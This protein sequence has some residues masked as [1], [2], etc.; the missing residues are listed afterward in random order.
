MELGMAEVT[1][2]VADRSPIEVRTNMESYECR[3]LILSGGAS[4]K[5]LG[6]PGEQELIGKGV[7]YCAH[8]DGGQFADKS[9]V[10]VGGGNSGLT[11]A[12]YLS[13]IASRITILEILPELR[14]LPLLVDR[15]REQ[16]NIDVR[17]GVRISAIEGAQRV[18]G[19]VCCEN[20]GAQTEQVATDGVLVRIGYDPETE[21]L[22]ESVSLDSLGFVEVDLK[23]ATS[24]PGVFAAGDIRAGSPMQ[25]ASAV[26]DGAVAAISAQAYLS[27]R[28]DG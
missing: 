13:R 27:E 11:D 21:Y 25:I 19:V 4:P 18:T 2:V 20:G 14:A 8:C 6:I 12:L 10:V 17:C 26:G 22:K 1:E 15:I 7:G 28:V 3:T 5:T 16:S 23:M 24:V 9:V